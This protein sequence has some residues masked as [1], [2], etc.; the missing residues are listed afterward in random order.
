MRS[1][2]LGGVDLELDLSDDE[3]DHLRRQAAAAGLSEHDYAVS[4]IR[5]YLRQF[6]ETAPEKRDE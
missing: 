2:Y 5:V 1:T 6:A 4:A 3:I